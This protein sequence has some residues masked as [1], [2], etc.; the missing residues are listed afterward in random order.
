MSRIFVGVAVPWGVAADS[1]ARDALA[2]QTDRIAEPEPAGLLAHAR[3]GAASYAAAEVR[4]ALVA[5]KPGVASAGL[6]G[7]GGLVDSVGQWHERARLLPDG[8]AEVLLT[9]RAWAEVLLGDVQRWPEGGTRLMIM[10]AR[11]VTS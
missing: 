4:G 1:F 2:R 9:N 8:S 6:Y 11:A 3:I 10:L 5:P 7:L